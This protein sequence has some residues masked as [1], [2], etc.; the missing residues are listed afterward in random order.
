[1][2]FILGSGFRRNDVHRLARRLSLVLL[3]LC[4]LGF[5]A[6]ASAAT[7]WQ[8]WQAARAHDPEFRAAKAALVKART[9]KPAAIAS[10]L[11]QVNTSL[12]RSYDNNSSNGPQYFGGSGILPVSQASNTGTSLWQIELDQPL[13]DWAAIKNMQAANLDV[14]AAAAT[15]QSTLDKLAAKVTQA[16]LN[17]LG[18]R[19]ALD[20][21]R[22]TVKGFAEQSREADARYHAGTTGVIGAD[23]ARAGLES[24]RGQLLAARQALTAADNALAALTGGVR[25]GRQ[26]TLP[27]HY[28]VSVAGAQKDWLDRALADNPRLAAARLGSQADAKRIGAADSGY[29]PTISLALIHNQQIQSGNASYS[30]PGQVVPTPAD[31]NATGNEIAVK[32]SWNIFAGGATRAKVSKA[33][34]QADQ[35]R[36]DA[37]TTRLDV[38]REVKTRYAA[39]LVD[40]QRLKTLRGA[41]TAARNAVQATTRG[42]SAGVRTQN[43]LVTQRE[44]LLSAEQALNLAISQA[45]ED[46]IALAQVSG[47]LTDKRLRAISRKL[48]ITS[49]AA[50]TVH[51]PLPA[52]EGQGESESLLD[53]SH[54]AASPH[55]RI[56]TFS[57]R[58]K[59]NSANKSNH[60]SKPTGVNP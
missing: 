9:Q 10:L 16:Y 57:Q 7:L 5:A 37:A 56:P 59:E 2:L 32:L 20:A 15:Y 30:T 35:S 8:A 38:K 24:A 33:R 39:L 55:T 36:A 40:A 43:E 6:S 11:P 58:E 3:F 18:A 22:E 12:A 4:L 48:A 49:P 41:V 21:T 28:R 44:R 54:N 25:P 46:E 53:A 42:V 51:S 45:V 14:A 31:L 17:V 47:T 29:M 19:A 52:G 27:N 34:A 23:A 60:V 50:S 26:A 13:F 1:M